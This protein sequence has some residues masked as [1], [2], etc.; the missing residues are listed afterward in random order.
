MSSFLNA[1]YLHLEQEHG[2]YSLHCALAPA[3]GK[4]NKQHKQHT[5]YSYL[6]SNNHSSNQHNKQQNNIQMDNSAIDNSNFFWTWNESSCFPTT[7]PPSQHSIQLPVS[8]VRQH[9]AAAETGNKSS[10]RLE[11]PQQIVVDIC[12]RLLKA[13]CF[14]TAAGISLW[15]PLCTQLE[16]QLV[17][18][19]RKTSTSYSAL[20]ICIIY[21]V[22]FKNA[23][24][25]SSGFGLC[26]VTVA[27]GKELVSNPFL[28]FATALL[29]ALKFLTDKH[30]SNER[31][32]C[33]CG[34]CAGGLPLD[35]NLAEKQ[36]LSV[37]AY[38]LYVEPQLIGQLAEMIIGKRENT[39]E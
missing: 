36:F 14:H 11:K 18:L 10:P 33:Y 39:I 4:R 29:L 35:V 15:D 9:S 19:L 17:S 28:L 38:D 16:K 5:E 21:L 8:T 24:V 3:K 2:D 13:M 1:N 23:A 31:W 26:S 25:R 32:F 27:S 34:I 37:I 20:L 22:R 6:Y 12:I 30:I 7:L